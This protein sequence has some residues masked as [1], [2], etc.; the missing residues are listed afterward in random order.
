MRTICWAA[1]RRAWS[2]SDASCRRLDSEMSLMIPKE[3]RATPCTS[4]TGDIVRETSAR[5]PSL[6]C[7]RASRPI[8]EASRW[9]RAWSSG[10][11]SWPSSVT[12]RTWCRPITSAASKP[13]IASAA[14]FQTVTVP[15]AAWP[16]MASMDESSSVDIIRIAASVRF[17]SLMS[18]TAAET[19]VAVGVFGGLSEIST[20]SSL[21]GVPGVVAEPQCPHAGRRGRWATGRACAAEGIARRRGIPARR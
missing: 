2:A 4:K 20:G 19:S 11:L 3:P 7:A 17:R 6:C 18:P 13:N 10:P 15:S 16:T 1:A 14:G 9:A 21:T 8:T 12:M 5:D